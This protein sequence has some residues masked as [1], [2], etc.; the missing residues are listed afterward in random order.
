LSNSIY[1]LVWN[2][3]SNGTYTVTARATDNAGSTMDW[4]VK[5]SPLAKAAQA[6]SLSFA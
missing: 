5:R 2:N 6:A 3:M 1:Q 4:T